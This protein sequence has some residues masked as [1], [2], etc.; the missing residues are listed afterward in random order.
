MCYR[1]MSILI[2][3]LSITLCASAAEL[4][5]AIMAGWNGTKTCERL[6]EDENI[7]VARCTFPPGVGHERHYHPAHYLYVLSGGRVRR[8]D[9]TGTREGTVTPG[10]FSSN[11]A[12]EW[13]ELINVGDTTLQY[14]ILEKK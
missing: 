13:H 4:P 14:L 3:A 10:R 2:A 9:A 5:D 8:T 7:R 6:F 11:A 12:V 1:Q